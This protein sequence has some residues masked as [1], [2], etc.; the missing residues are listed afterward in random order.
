MSLTLK[1]RL[2]A[3]N[4]LQKGMSLKGFKYSGFGKPSSKSSHSIA[5]TLEQISKSI[6]NVYRYKKMWYECQ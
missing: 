2:L 4:K 3:Y 1:L 6:E 5:K